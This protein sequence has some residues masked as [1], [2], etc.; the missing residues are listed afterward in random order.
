[1]R[2]LIIEDA[3]GDAPPPPTFA[4]EPLLED[5]HLRFVRCYNREVSESYWKVHKY[6]EKD[7]TG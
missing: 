2:L 6:L 4:N 3:Y 7:V 5:R 1:M